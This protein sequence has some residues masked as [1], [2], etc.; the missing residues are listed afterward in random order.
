MAFEHLTS[1]K[2]PSLLAWI[3]ALAT[4]LFLVLSA[5]F[6]FITGTRV[7]SELARRQANEYLRTKEFERALL[8]AR[9][10]LTP[11]VD[12]ELYETLLGKDGTTLSKRQLAAVTE[13]ITAS[14]NIQL[15]RVMLGVTDLQRGKSETIEPFIEQ[16]KEENTLLSRGR[17]KLLES[18]LS[19]ALTLAD[20]F[21]RVDLEMTQLEQKLEQLKTE[22]SQNEDRFRLVSQSTQEI[23]S[24]SA[25]RPVEAPPFQ[26]TLPLYK[27]GVLAGLPQLSGIP[28]DIPELPQL[29]EILIRAGGAVSLQ[30]EAFIST[31]AKIREN[32]A[33]ILEQHTVLS[34]RGVELEEALK[35]STKSQRAILFQMTKELQLATELLLNPLTPPLEP[36]SRYLPEGLSKLLDLSI[37]RKTETISI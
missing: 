37:Q 2:Q 6:L 15:K 11:S 19:K 32:T 14:E 31:L 18:R 1:D 3:L 27:A 34:K 5:G 4:L 21:K 9:A 35:L 22:L 33:L 36:W 8:L 13:L 23:F 24:V 25:V 17:V 28:D 7:E 20:S 29:R 16:L 10:G 12:Q 30:Y 26:R